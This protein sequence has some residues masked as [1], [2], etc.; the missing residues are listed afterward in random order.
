MQMVLT[1]KCFQCNKFKP[2][3][4]FHKDKQ[5]HDGLCPLCKVCRNLAAARSNK[6]NVSQVRVSAAA[7]YAANPEPAKLRAK[8]W[9]NENPER[10][11]LLSKRWFQDNLQKCLLASAQW[12]KDHPELMRLYRKQWKKANP[13]SARIYE[14]KKV[15]KAPDQYIKQLICSSNVGLKTT[16]IPLPL[17]QAKRAHLQLAR[18]I[19]ELKK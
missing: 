13:E 16:D 12:Q 9:R 17:I 19:K 5:K 4:G 6:K 10:K 8:R 3:D 1:K 15:K 7:R 2:L 11:K 14:M 18:K